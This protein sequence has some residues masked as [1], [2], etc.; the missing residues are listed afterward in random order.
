MKE[1][2]RESLHVGNPA[3][4]FSAAES[5]EPERRGWDEEMYNRKKKDTNNHYDFSRK[6]L[7]FEINSKGEIVPLGSNPPPLHERIKQR[8]DELGFVPYYEQDRPDVIADNSPNCTVTMIFSGN[9]DVL[10]RLAFGEENVDFTLKKKKKYAMHI[11]PDRKESRTGQ[12]TLTT[13]FAD[14]M[15]QKT[16]SVLMF[17]LM[18]RLPMRMF[19]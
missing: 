6:D 15:E 7:N 12:R 11:S 18:K 17:I 4:S 9:H 13:S 3:K 2:A 1:T 8:L 19:R 10:S 14:A 16:S 5:A